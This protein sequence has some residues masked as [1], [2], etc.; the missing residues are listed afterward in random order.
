MR[1]LLLFLVQQIVDRPEKVEVT[2]TIDEH[3]VVVLSLEADSADM[4][5]V[6]GKQGRIIKA[7]RTLVGIKAAKEGKRVLVALQ[8]SLPPPALPE[9]ASV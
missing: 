5:K 9:T 7:L 1:D 3:Q 2:E 8:E 6:I 4:G